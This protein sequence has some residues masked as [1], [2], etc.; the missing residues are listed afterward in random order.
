MPRGGELGGVSPRAIGGIELRSIYCLVAASNGPT[1]SRH[2]VS[3][4]CMV[5]P[6]RN[7][8]SLNALFSLS[9]R[10]GFSP[11]VNVVL[12]QVGPDPERRTSRLHHP[13]CHQLD[14]ADQ[15]QANVDQS[16]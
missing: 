9:A 11:L 13:S 3:M 4:P 8:R 2:N 12:M 10:S 5:S 14:N 6:L 16:W 7:T 15:V 1:G